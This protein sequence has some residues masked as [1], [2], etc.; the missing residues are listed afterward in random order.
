MVNTP[1][2]T[3]KSIGSGLKL[4]KFANDCPDVN[5]QQ[6]NNPQKNKKHLWNQHVL[7]IYNHNYVKSKNHYRIHIIINESTCG[8]D[9]EVRI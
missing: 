5:I 4:P 1:N 6:N 8:N 3:A 7:K 9:S 2:G